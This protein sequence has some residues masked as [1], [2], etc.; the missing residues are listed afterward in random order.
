MAEP[1]ST[2][3]TPDDLFKPYAAGMRITLEGAQAAT[4]QT[5]RE[6]IWSRNKARAYHYIPVT[7][8]HWRVPIL[9]VYS[10]INRPY[11][12]DLMPGNSLVEYLVGQGCDV[13]LLDW[14]VPGDED[15]QLSLDHYV[16]DYLPAAIRKVLRV[17]G[18]DAFTLFGYCMGGTLA[19]MYAALFPDPPL[20]NLVLLTTPIDFLPEHTGNLGLWTNPQYLD[21][22][23]LV[24]ALGNIPG[25]LI[26]TAMR[27]LKPLPN[28]L[29]TPITMWDRLLE[30]KP[31]ETWLAMNKW[32]NDGIPFPGAAFRQM[33]RL[34]QRNSLARGEFTL[35]GRP[36]DL[37]GITCAVLNIAG[38]N[39]HIVPIAQT[40][41][42]LQ[43]IA[44][45]DKESLVLD[46][47]HVG[48]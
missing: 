10:L 38:T 14:G 48:M 24:E 35:R 30:G 23:H 19:A 1:R 20:K 7:R 16:L 43:R 11:I 6:V 15:A 21:V 18:A 41:T 47:G 13:Y 44:S 45:G 17:A 27:M 32:V 31:M 3:P 9:L 12:L 28:Y 8:E 29:G 2:P 33:L 34:Y 36:V 46:A 39:D 25:G 4:G 40:A 37:A 26:D 5:P 42:T 22:D